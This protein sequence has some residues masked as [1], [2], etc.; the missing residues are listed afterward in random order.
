MLESVFLLSGSSLEEAFK[1][2]GPQ[3]LGIFHT[4]MHKGL[5]ESIWAGNK[6]DG[7]N[8]TKTDLESRLDQMKQLLKE[9]NT[10]KGN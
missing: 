8:L 10:A 5:V 6:D 1:H 7:V 2:A 9:D 3:A 4:P